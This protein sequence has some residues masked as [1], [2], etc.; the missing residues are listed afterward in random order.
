MDV[1][2]NRRAEVAAVAASGDDRGWQGIVG[3][4]RKV[5]RL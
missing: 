1:P 2:K 5:L 3:W 4:N